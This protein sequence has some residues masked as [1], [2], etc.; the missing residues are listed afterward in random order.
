MLQ[1]LSDLV[2]CH[3]QLLPTVTVSGENIGFGEV[4]DMCW[5]IC[6]ISPG[7]ISEFLQ[8]HLCCEGQA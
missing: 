1:T 8:F 6:A 2:L 5:D 7:P 4:V 3:N